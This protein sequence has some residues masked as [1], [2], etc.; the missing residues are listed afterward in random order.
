MRSNLVPPQHLVMASACGSGAN[1]HGVTDKSCVG[2]GVITLHNDITCPV[3]VLLRYTKYK[4]LHVYYI[5]LPIVNVNVHV[6][7]KTVVLN[8]IS[9]RTLEA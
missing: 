2:R 7:L 4:Q 6:P 5:P 3:Q 9:C 8:V 1:S